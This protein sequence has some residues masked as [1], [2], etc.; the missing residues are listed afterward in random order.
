[1]PKEFILHN[2]QALAL[3]S[4]FQPE[5]NVFGFLSGKRGG[6][7]ICG[8][9]FAFK[10]LC[11]RP[12]ELGAIASPTSEQLTHFTL[13]EFK[14]VLSSYGLKQDEHYVVNINPK[15]KFG[16]DSKF[17][18]NHY[19][20]WSFYWGAQVY[21][22]SI[23]SFFMGAEF[24]WA[25]LDEIQN[26]SKAQLDEV[27]IRMSGSKSPKT[28]YTFTPP[29]D[30][31]D[32]D[33]M[34]YGEDTD[35]PG[36]GTLKLVVGTTFDNQKN[37]E[38]TYLPML[39]NTL[40]PIT[41][42]RDVMCRRVPSTGF[43][44]LYSF[45]KQKHVSA[46]AIYRAQEM[47][48]VSFDFNNNPFVCLLSHRGVD[49]IK[50]KRYIHYFDEIEL[51]P[52]MVKNRTFI[53]AMA[54]QIFMRTEFQQKHNLY[55]VTGDASG[56]H[57]QLTMRVGENVW[58]ELVKEMRLGNGQLK[59][60][61]S[62]M[63]HSNSRELCNGLLANSHKVD[64]IE[65]LINPK[66]KGQISDCEYVQAKSNGD[67]EKRETDKILKDSRAI[68]SQKADFLD[69]FRYDIHAFNGDYFRG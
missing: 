4:V 56:N 5:N 67:R 9:H 60:S 66:N 14:N 18:S 52:S 36:T 17:P 16:Y 46:E 48:Y 7:S 32:I 34:V 2:K 61:A 55:M 38:P 28:F 26:M 63:R 62:N 8:S 37:L 49:P 20:V 31:P 44:W 3:A 23:E 30:N 58:T 40:D 10:L 65:V 21:T 59:V 15:A 54:E 53:Q 33:K 27:L 43:P 12:Q 11:D 50:R 13:S 45:D 64:G 39:E 25:W 51:K 19:G 6:K 42:Q 1:M 47:V 29:K 69:A 22:F 41:F 24:G 68:Q 57:Q 35:E